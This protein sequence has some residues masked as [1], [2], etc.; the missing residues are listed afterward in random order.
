MRYLINV[1]RVGERTLTF[2]TNNTKDAKALF[3]RACFANPY[4]KVALLENKPYRQVLI[5]LYDY[6]TEVVKSY[7]IQHGL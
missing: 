4:N 7:N 2:A 3:D 6:N 5:D 1:Y